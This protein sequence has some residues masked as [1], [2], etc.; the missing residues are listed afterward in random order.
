M[1]PLARVLV[2]AIWLYRRAVSPLLPRTCRFEPTCS[3][4]A[5]EAVRTH[6]GLRGTA[7]AVRRIARCHPWGDGGLDPVPPRKVAA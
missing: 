6:G 2:G 4:Y 3:A 1:S 7:L 5:L